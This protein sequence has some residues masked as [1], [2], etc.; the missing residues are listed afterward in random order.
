MLGI[1]YSANTVS[2]LALVLAIGI[3]V[4]DAIVV[5]ENVERVLEEEP[6]L[7]VKEATRKAMGEITAPIIAITLVL[8]SVFVPVAFIPG[9][10]GQL[11]RQFAVAVSVSMIISAI[12]A[13]SLSPALCSIL[14][15]H[16]HG[17]P[18]GPVGWMLA[19][20]DKMTEGYTWIVRRLVRV[21]IVSLAVLAG[22]FL[23]TGVIFKTTPK[24]F[25]PDEDQGA[26]FAIVQLPEGASQNRTAATATQLDEIIRREPE[27]ESAT[28]VIGYDFINAI[29]S[30]NKGFF[31]IRLKH[32]EDRH[33]AEHSAAAL[34]ERLRRQF[35]AVG[36]GL[37][38]PL[39]LPPIIGLGTSGGFQ[40]VLEALQG[41]PFSDVAAVLRNRAIRPIR[42]ASLRRRSIGSRR[43]IGGSGVGGGMATSLQPSGQREQGGVARA[44]PPAQRRVRF[45][46][47]ALI[48]DRL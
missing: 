10:T 48:D 2:L 33:G 32:F 37:A 23:L 28:G 29:A 35:A 26:L 15:T 19:G 31:I 41:Q 18:R 12:N 44:R 3:V 1:G 43:Q 36:T 45:I 34:I 40:Y 47:A 27:V 4:D 7:S 24:G 5:I 39:N 46:P 25:L 11:F 16:S 6:E 9:I 38:V 22:V 42:T 8:L 17:R 14:L 20:I 13:L 21:S 30:S